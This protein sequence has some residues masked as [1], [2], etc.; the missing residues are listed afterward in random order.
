MSEEGKEPKG[1][2]YELKRMFN[3]LEKSQRLDY[4]PRDF[5]YSFDKNIKL[6]VQ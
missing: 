1:I 2:L 6:H 3:Y 5:C 4:N